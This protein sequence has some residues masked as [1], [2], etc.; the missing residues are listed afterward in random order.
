MIQVCATKFPKQT[1]RLVGW[2]VGGFGFSYNLSTLDDYL[3]PN[4]V[5]TYIFIKCMICK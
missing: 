2:L 3:I 4:P 5:Y 1:N